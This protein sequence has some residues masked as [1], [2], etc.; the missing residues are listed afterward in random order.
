MAIPGVHSHPCTGLTCHVIT[1]VQVG[2]ITA[3][4]LLTTTQTQGDANTFRTRQ[5]VMTP[6]ATELGRVHGGA[7][8]VIMNTMP[9]AAKNRDVRIAPT[10]LYTV[11]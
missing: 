1:R 11:D 5:S 9:K 2:S 10:I 3:L 8:L 4:E 6:V 7:T